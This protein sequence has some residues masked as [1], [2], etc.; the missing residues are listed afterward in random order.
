MVRHL[1]SGFGISERRAC[2]LL[3]FSR[4][5]CRYQCKRPPQDALWRRIRK[6]ALSRVRYGYKRVHVLLKR[7][8]IHVNKKRVHR[9]YCLEGFQLRHK[10]PKRRVSGSQRVRDMIKATGPNEAWAMDFMTDQLVDGRRFRILTVVDTYTRECLAADAR[11]RQRAPDVVTTLN[12]ILKKRDKPTKIFCD[13]GSEF[14]GCVTDLWAY[15]CGIKLAF[16][17]PAR[18]LIMP[19]SSHSMVVFGTSA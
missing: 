4:T 12:N 17:R 19:T 8:G 11:L 18:Q 2:G 6:I 15:Q 5:A 16:L 9:L 14:A 10:R 1:Q 3:K 13:N 7:E